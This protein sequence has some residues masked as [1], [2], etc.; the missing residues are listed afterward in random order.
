MRLSA[1]LLILKLLCK[2]CSTSDTEASLKIL[3]GIVSANRAQRIGDVRTKIKVIGAHVS[4]AA[5]Q[6]M[7]KEKDSKYKGHA[8][9]CFGRNCT[10]HLDLEL[11][12]YGMADWVIIKKS[13]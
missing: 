12:K 11:S 5:F 2:F 7:Y 6:C 4:L 1:V 10:M 13:N 9:V 8:T 3:R